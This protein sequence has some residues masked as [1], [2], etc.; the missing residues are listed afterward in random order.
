LAP[1]L[2][3]DNAWL[4]SFKTSYLSKD[5]HRAWQSLYQGHPVSEEGEIVKRSWWQYYKVLPRDLEYTSMSVDA[6]FKDA[7]TSDFVAIEI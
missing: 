1:E 4:K 3:R 6:T 7:A 2:G 5:G